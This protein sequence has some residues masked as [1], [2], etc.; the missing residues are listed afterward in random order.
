MLVAAA[1]YLLGLVALVL[2]PLGDWLGRLT[3]RLYVVWVYDLRLPGRV[4][5]DDVGFALNVVLFVPLGVLLTLSTRRPV[6]S[7]VAC[8]VGSST[9]EL[10]QL[11]PQLHRD[12]SVLDVV[13][14]GLGGL[15]GALAAW[16][17]SRRVRGGGRW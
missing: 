15:L 8:V 9:I 10:V 2:L 1:A 6:W 5:P 14:N 4:M 13:A 11:L 7:V 3:V 16:L 17:L 12:S